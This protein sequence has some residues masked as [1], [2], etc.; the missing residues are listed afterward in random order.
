VADT[1]NNRAMIYDAILATPTPTATPT[2][3][4]T[5]TGTASPTVS[6]TMTATAT[7][8][9]SATP[10]A[11]ATATAS[12]TP[13]PVMGG[14]LQV[15]PKSLKFGKVAIGSRSGAQTIKIENAG[16]VTM[17]AAVPT[18]GAPFV[19][20]GG[21]FIVGAHGS[22]SVTIQF[23]PTVKGTEHGKLT[24]TSSDPKRRSVIV[25]MSGRGT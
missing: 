8:T 23:A 16:T 6:S 25:K 21:E 13:T 20:T 7:A 19:V 4:A 24:I 15:R 1:N 11:T 3:S 9:T 18:L 10:T 17:A 2:A 12:P 14:K 22:M 5:A